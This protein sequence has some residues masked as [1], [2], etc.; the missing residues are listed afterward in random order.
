MGWRIADA[1]PSDVA[2][3]IDDEDGGRRESIAVKV[4]YVVADGDVV[5]LAGVEDREF[6]S[7]FGDDRFGS[8]EVVGADGQDFCARV[9]DLRVVF[10]QLT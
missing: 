4:E 8:A 3:G 1:L 5:V 2:V 10:L 6:R 9:C 7:G